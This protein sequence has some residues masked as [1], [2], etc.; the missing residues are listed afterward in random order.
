MVHFLLCYN[1]TGLL[2]S[3]CEYLPSRLNLPKRRRSCDINGEQVLR[4]SV[5][6][7]S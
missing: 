4:E 3:M 1:L 5:G 2:G 6:V 7:C